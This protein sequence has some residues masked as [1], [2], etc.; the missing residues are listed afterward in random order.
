MSK[1]FSYSN[2]SASVYQ[3]S[4]SKSVY[5]RHVNKFNKKSESTQYSAGPMNS[6]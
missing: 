6:R 3:S 5:S 1:G 4:N 2:G